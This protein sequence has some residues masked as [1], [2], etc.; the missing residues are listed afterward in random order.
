[1]A[2]IPEFTR[3]NPLSQVAAAPASPQAAGAGWAALA[4]LAKQGAEFM[5]P[6]AMKQAR[7]EGLNSVYRDAD[8]TLKVAEKSALG[9]ELADAHNSAGFAK[10]LAQRKIDMSQTFTELAQKY[11][12]DPAGF[13]AASDSYMKIMQE[14]ETAPKAVRDEL[15]LS[16]QNEANQRF[17]G[18]YQ[19]ETRRTYDDAN[20]NTR[21]LREM[22]A[23]D[24]VNLVLGGDPD[25]AAA[26][27]KEMEELSTFRANAP[28][29]SETPAETDTFLRGVRGSAK[30]AELTQ[31]LSGLKGA[32]EI[33][34]DLRKQIMNTLK[35]PD[36]S[37]DARLKLYS[38]AEGTLK[39][40]DAAG[41]VSGLTD[42]S[43]GAKVVRAE[44]GGN[45]GGS[46]PNSSALGLH[47]FLSGTWMENVR[48]LRALGGATWADGMS[49]RE[50]LKMRKDRSASTEVF[51]HFTAKNQRALR[52]AGLPVNDATS[53]MAH[54]FGIGGAIKVLGSDPSAQ[55]ADLLPEVVRANS[56]MG[57]MTVS[58]A[59]N[60][61]ARKMTM[62]SSDI[63]AQQVVIDQIPDAEV[64]GMASD[65]L[66]AQLAARKNV[67]AAALAGYEERLATP[68]GAPAISE[69]YQDQNLSD[70]Q[71][72]SLVKRLE[73]RNSDAVTIQQTIAALSNPEVHMNFAEGK[74]RSATDKAY[75][76]LIGDDTPL[77]AAGM[78]V[79][80]EVVTAKGY[81][82][83][84]AF[85]GVLAAVNGADPEALA[86]AMEF[87]N[88]TLDRQPSA[89][90]Y[91]DRRSNVTDAL[92]DY[93]FYSGFMSG[94]EAAARMIEDRTPE[95]IAKRKNLSDA[96]KVAVK[97]L[98]TDDLVNYLAG[99]NVSVVL[100]NEGQQGEMMA[101]YERL[102]TDAFINTGDTGRAKERA[103][104]ELS[105][106]YGPDL[107]TGSKTLMKFPPQNF[108]PH[109]VNADPDWMQKQLVQDV[110]DSILGNDRVKI[111]SP[112]MGGR[113]LSSG[114]PVY[115]IDEVPVDRITIASDEA[116]RRDVAAGR[117]PSYMV[118][119]FDDD[120][121]WN[122]MPKRF[123]FDPSDA[124]A[125]SKLIGMA[126]MKDAGTF[127]AEKDRRDN[128]IAW[129]N[130]L[131]RKFGTGISDG[132][133]ADDMERYATTKPPEE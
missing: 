111:Q 45:T 95:A 20:R 68:N 85:D 9:G 118:G 79:A 7:D 77:S 15:S 130:Y 17:N 103:L 132:S 84:P 23:D 62:K 105:R 24:Y 29:I 38:A 13:K 122:A 92:A 3:R 124:I 126:Y 48:E 5:K 56:F 104:G 81:L 58:D 46:D 63:A 128:L 127:S 72:I 117:A 96:A 75:S 66:K 19:Q 16:A 121:S 14:D 123:R 109:P 52:A 18:L 21:A 112:S 83:K 32:T 73:A 106:V 94:P 25:G 74:T 4:E 86:Q 36:L 97:T 131:V 114:A 93:R 116:T 67:E 65:L 101:E 26:K 110:S 60:W 76:A 61:A 44:S 78:Q 107:I 108:Y 129:D 113:S 47:Q 80:A 100:G 35:D 69:V 41:I 31:T 43:Y 27:M 119:Y 125:D 2:R 49:T 40:I 98:K 90:L 87:T 39:G 30:V 89:I 10:Y 53:Y 71:Q 57:G 88:S 102:F 11:Q 133:T 33:S 8:G 37:P 70:Q 82:P 99:K 54:F 55:I 6:A 28:Y 120:G 91:H 1:M 64:R 50:I 51:N 12:F 22:M 115:S 42:S 34:K 59:V